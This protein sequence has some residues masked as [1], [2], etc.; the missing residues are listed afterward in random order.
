VLQKNNTAGKN[1]LGEIKAV[2]GVG[3]AFNIIVCYQTKQ[4]KKNP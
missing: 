2:S 1:A 3:V 4:T